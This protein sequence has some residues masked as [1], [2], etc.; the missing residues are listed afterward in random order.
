[1]PGKE[2]PATI[3]MLKATNSFLRTDCKLSDDVCTNLSSQRV[4]VS[5][6]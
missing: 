2:G 4:A 6:A 1:M 3:I 5:T